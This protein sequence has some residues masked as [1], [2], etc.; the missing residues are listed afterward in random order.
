MFPIQ[1]YPSLATQV[2]QVILPGALISDLTFQ[3]VTLEQEP[4]EE[5]P[6]VKMKS[7]QL[8]PIILEVSTTHLRITSVSVI[9]SS[10]NV[11]LI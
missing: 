4:S 3:S 10:T 11:I 2:G 6:L 8:R 9:I 7:P 1:F 5:F